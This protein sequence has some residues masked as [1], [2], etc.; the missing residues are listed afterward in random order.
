[1]G[2]PADSKR[3]RARRGAM[4]LAMRALLA[5]LALCMA[6]SAA[7][8]EGCNR[9]LRMAVEHRPPY[10]YMDPQGQMRGGDFELIK[11]I[12]EQAGCKL[13]LQSELPRKRRYAMFIAGEIDL[14]ASASDT[15]ERRRVAWF[16]A[17]YYTETVALF[18]LPEQLQAL[19]DITGFGDVLKRR[20]SVVSQSFGWYGDD[21]EGHKPALREAGLLSHYDQLTSAIG[22][23][24]LGRGQMLLADRA[25]TRQL[26]RERGV[27]FAELPYVPVQ[28]PAHIMLSRQSV[29]EAEFQAIDRALKRLEERGT[30]KQ[31]RLKYGLQ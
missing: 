5:W 2:S 15:P 30:L 18:V 10:L 14:L 6:G 24:Q 9:A 19:Q 25:A 20:L 13:A 28:A 22:M 8:A 23:L 26:L 17:P 31:I 7:R 4:R 11:A 21:F 16:T 12:V 27:N 1:M 3:Q 29:S